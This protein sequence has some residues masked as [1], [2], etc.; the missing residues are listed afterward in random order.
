MGGVWERLI[1]S[2]RKILGALLTK[3]TVTDEGLPT[4]TVE[5][6]SIMNSRLLTHL[7]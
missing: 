4:V 2:A 7:F 1:S 6:E 3:E 5:V